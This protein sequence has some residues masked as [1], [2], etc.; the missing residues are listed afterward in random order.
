[1]VLAADVKADGNK[2]KFCYVVNRM[3]EHF[4]I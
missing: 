1:M 2:L 3:S 4:K